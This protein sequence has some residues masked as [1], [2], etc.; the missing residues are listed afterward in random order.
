MAYNLINVDFLH[1]ISKTYPGRASSSPII[2]SLITLLHLG[3]SG[4]NELITKR[5]NLY[6]YLKQELVAISEKFGE[7][8]LEVPENPISLAITLCT[9]PKEDLTK[10]GSMLFLRNIS[11][12]RVITTVE[13]KTIEGYKFNGWGS[14][15]DSFKVPYLTAAASIGVEKTE[16]DGFIKKLNSVLLKLQKECKN[17]KNNTL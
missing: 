15:C 5:D 17:N 11:G 3:K 13:F 8:V 7:K 14:H 16:I 6:L 1:K 2:D 9:I 4:Y 12:T 10:L